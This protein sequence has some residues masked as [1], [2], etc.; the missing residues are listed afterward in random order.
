MTQAN[1]GLGVTK[2]LG[3]SQTLPWEGCHTMSNKVPNVVHF[4]Y[5]VWER[6]RPLSYLNYMAVKMAEEVQEPDEIKFWINKEPEPSEWWD[7]IKE[8]V[9]IY[10]TPMDGKHLGVNIEWP[11]LQSDLTRLEILN[12]EGG[13]YL[14]TDMLLLHPLSLYMDDDFSM[15]LEPSDGPPVS[16]CNA[17]MIAKPDAQFTKLWLEEMP[18]ALAHPVWAYGG[19]KV[20]FELSQAYPHLVSM[21]PSWH[22]CP[23]DLK[24]NWLFS[25]DPEIFHEANK[26]SQCSAAVH[27]FETFWRDIV[28]DITPQWCKDNPH[29][30]F[31]VLTE[32]HRD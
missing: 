22:F 12:N 11:Q 29:S 30:L 16:A 3:L 24:Q 5:P 26:R 9:T 25:T 2:K 17:L 21:Y 4:I 18:A 23:L 14:D 27:G 19:V 28:K 13:I 1:V 8:L 6:T 20:P 7:K 32:P 10:H 31:S 15:C